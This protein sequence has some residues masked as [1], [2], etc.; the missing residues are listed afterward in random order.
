MGIMSSKLNKKSFLW[1]FLYIFTQIYVQNCSHINNNNIVPQ[2]NA[3]N[4]YVLGQIRVAVGR[5]IWVR[6]CEASSISWVWVGSTG[7]VGGCKWSNWSWGSE[8]G[9]VG[10]WD[11][12]LGR[13]HWGIESTRKHLTTLGYWYTVCQRGCS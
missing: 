11:Y 10:R 8:S 2:N 6:V 1:E 3:L 13:Y 12:S 9:S 7:G 5:S 4:E